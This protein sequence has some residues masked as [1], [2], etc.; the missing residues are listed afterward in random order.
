VG[1]K[2]MLPQLKEERFAYKITEERIYA[3]AVSTPPSLLKKK[4]VERRFNESS[5]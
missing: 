5:K 1:G 3:R 4:Y 2:A